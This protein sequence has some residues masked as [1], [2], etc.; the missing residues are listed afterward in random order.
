MKK[1]VLFSILAMNFTASAFAALPPLYESINE[2]KALLTDS[3]LTH[4]LESGEIINA[5]TRNETGF[6]IDTNKHRLTVKMIADPQ[7]MPG[8]AKFHYEFGIPTNN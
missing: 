1:T 2:Y 8:P 4:K 5:I 7:K 3:Q 6:I